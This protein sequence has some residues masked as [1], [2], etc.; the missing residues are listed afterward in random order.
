MTMNKK[1]SIRISDENISHAKSQDSQSK[2]FNRL[3]ERER[4]DDHLIDLLIVNVR[5][6][7]EGLGYDKNLAFKFIEQAVN[8]RLKMTTV[9]N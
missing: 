7:L 3:I 8:N 6:T 5:K 1:Y 2:Y 4:S 9:K